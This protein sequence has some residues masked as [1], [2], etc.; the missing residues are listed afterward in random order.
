MIFGNNLDEDD[1][2]DEDDEF[3]DDED[4]E[5]ESLVL[6][7]IETNKLNELKRNFLLDKNF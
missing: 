5:Y 6:K 3:V 2:Y 4:A 1:G 7:A